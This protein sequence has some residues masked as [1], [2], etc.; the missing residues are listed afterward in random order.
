VLLVLGIALLSEHQSI[1]GERI[2]NTGEIVAKPHHRRRVLSI[3]PI[4][5]V[6]II[7]HNVVRRNNSSN[8][9]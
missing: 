7:L 2:G 1:V 4:S 5:G 6:S 8:K 9:R 3:D